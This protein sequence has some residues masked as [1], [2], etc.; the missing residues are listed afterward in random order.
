MLTKVKIIAT[1]AIIFG[2]VIAF[3]LT[4]HSQVKKIPQSP[5]ALVQI[6]LAKKLP[7]AKTLTTYGTINI[8]PEH[9]QQ[10]TIQ[11]EALVQQIFVTQGQHVK[12]DDPLIRLSTTSGSSLN[13]QT[14]KI[15]VDFASK[16]LDRLE[17]SRA[18]FL[19]TNADV[20]TAKQN[21]AKAQATL[22]NL[23]QQQQNETGKILRSN[24]DCN[25]VA[26]NVQPGQIVSPA[27][28]LLT[29]ANISQVQIR[30][31]VESEDLPKIQV[32]QKVIIIPIYNTT[33]SYTGYINNI[34]D[35]ID[36]KTGLIDV[37]VPLGNI[38]GLIPG[39]MVKGL[40]FIENEKN[41]LAVPRSAVLHHDN[42]A[43]VF[44]DVNGKAQQRWVTVGD[45]NGNFVAIQS[46]LKAD[47][48]V[49]TVGNYELQNGM[50]IHA[51]SR[52]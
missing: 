1:T 36:P 2:I 38:T 16:E 15:A 13:L 24:C 34:T 31:G 25:I 3:I 14:A 50:D 11:N 37:I 30:L 18:Q 27:T 43:F 48:P 51:G 10:L 19:S 32:K 35:Q 5:S 40:I 33:V 46:G 49:V 12:L 41:M 20:Q 9:I 23:Q 28:T 8:A 4:H 39:S 6:T 21:L 26:I 47:E 44:V 17:K 22:N 45:N 42:K 7:M 52:P 29:Y